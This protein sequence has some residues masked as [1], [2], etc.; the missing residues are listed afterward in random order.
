VCIKRQTLR[1]NPGIITLF[2]LQPAKEAKWVS[3]EGA[4]IYLSVYPG[5]VSLRLLRCPKTARQRPFA[6]PF[7]CPA[8]GFLKF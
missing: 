3:N 1:P 8:H 7:R 4:A 2:L 6:T 5:D